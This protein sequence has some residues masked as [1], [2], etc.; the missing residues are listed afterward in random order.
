MA[1]GSCRVIIVVEGPSAAG[2]TSWVETHY[3]GQAVW[4]QRPVGTEPD[5]ATDPHGA[6]LFWAEANARRWEQALDTEA[7]HGLAVCDTDPFKL[8]Y[9]W[10]LC[11]V[12]EAP[13]SAWR[14]EV[15]INRQMFA[16]RRVGLADAAFCELPGRIELRRRRSVDVQ[17]RRRKFELHRRL[18]EPLRLWYQAVDQLDPGRV[19]WRLPR[20]PERV[21]FPQPRPDRSA[22]SLFDQLVG[23]LP[24]L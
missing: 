4:E 11:Y 12:G 15:E 17:R 13:V 7:E 1:L 22:L 19:L 16:A 23:S 14:A 5:R 18:D 9:V 21:E 10:S 6:A 20:H 24:P 3:R 8:H 2:K